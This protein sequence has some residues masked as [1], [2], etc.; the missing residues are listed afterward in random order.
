[1]AFSVAATT[2]K[3]NGNYTTPRDVTGGDR[4]GPERCQIALSGILAR[5]ANL[6]Y[7]NA[8]PNRVTFTPIRGCPPAYPPTTD[9][10]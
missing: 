5:G 6:P 7:P 8:Y 4:H 2:T 1:M 9:L 10:H 3:Q